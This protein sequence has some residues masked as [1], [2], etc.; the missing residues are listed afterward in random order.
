MLLLGFDTVLKCIKMGEMDKEG[1]AE[2]EE[3]SLKF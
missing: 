3:L 1:G 2:P